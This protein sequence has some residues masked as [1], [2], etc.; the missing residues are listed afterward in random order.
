MSAHREIDQK[1]AVRTAIGD[2][3]ERRAFLRDWP[4]SSTPERPMPT[5]TWEQLERQLIDLAD[6]PAKQALAPPLVSAMRKHSRWKPPEMVLREI[7]CLA[8][9]LMDEAFQPGPGPDGEAEMP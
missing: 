8:W 7:L 1:R 9:T 2:L 3:L 4:R 6:T 5:F